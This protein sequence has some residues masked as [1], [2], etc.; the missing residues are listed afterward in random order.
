MSDQLQMFVPGTC[1]VI[2][3]V[4][5][6]QASAGGV[7]RSSSQDGQKT[8]PPGPAP[9]HAKASPVLAKAKDLTTLAA[10]SGTT[11]CGLSASADLSESLANRLR[12]RLGTAGSIEYSQTWKLKATPAG[13]RYWAHTASALRTAGSDST[14]A[15]WPTP[16]A[17]LMNDGASY[18]HHMERMERLK[19]KHNNGNGAGLPLAISAQTAAPWPTPNTPSGGRSADPETM[20]ATGKTLDGKKHTASLEH[21]V[22]FSSWPTP[23]SEDGEQTGAHRGVPDTLNMASPWATPAARDYRSNEASQEHHAKR[24]AHSRGKPLSEEAH[25]LTSGPPQSG[26]P[27]ETVKRG[28]S[29]KLNPAFSAWLMGYPMA[30]TLAG[31]K[32]AFRS[33]KAKS[34]EGFRS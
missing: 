18:E 17:Q 2:R 10:N 11:L 5:S 16:D 4:I 19:A 12:Q 28:E 3:S 24:A 27:A 29:P 15:P 8:A 6:S 14:G 13:R 7:S 25:Q 31:L 26:T 21:A 20:D 33:R 23:R 1:T 9:A 30:W 22:K 32:A 34:K